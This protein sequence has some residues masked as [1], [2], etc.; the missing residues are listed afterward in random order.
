MLTT[1]ALI[2]NEAVE[3]EEDIGT[4]SVNLRFNLDILFPILSQKVW[5]RITRKVG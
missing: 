1:S 5:V 4:R 2:T 3:L